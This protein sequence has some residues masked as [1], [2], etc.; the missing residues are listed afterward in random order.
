[1]VSVMDRRT[2]VLF[3]DTQMLFPETL[4]YQHELAPAAGADGRAHPGARLAAVLAHDPDGV[5]HPTDPDACCALRKTEPLQEALAGFDAWITGRKR[6]QGGARAALDFF[7]T[8]DDIRIKVNPLAHVGAAG[9]AGL[10]RQQPPAPP[11]A[12]GAGLPLDRLRAL[13]QPRRPG[14]RPARRPLARHATRRNAASISS[15]AVPCA[16]RCRQETRHDRDR[17]RQGL[18]ARRLDRNRRAPGRTDRRHTGRPPSMSAPPT[19]WRSWPT[20]WRGCG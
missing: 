5:L 7:E 15:T 1:M 18:C 8:E 16:D 11:S 13:H 2:P 19:T 10:H 12:G 3:L 17:H 6:F 9:R 4:A 14:R 20:G